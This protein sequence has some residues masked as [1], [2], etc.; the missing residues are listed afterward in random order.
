MDFK[1][2]HDLPGR[3]RLRIPKGT[4]TKK[5]SAV[6]ETLLGV[7][8]DVIS[9]KVSF[10][11]DSILLKFH[12]RSRKKILTAVSLLTEDLCSDSELY[13]EDGQYDKTPWAG[14]AFMCAGAA[15]RMALPFPLRHI[16]ALYRSA[17]FVKK[18]IDSVFKAHKLNVSVLDASAI[19][20]AMLRGDFKAAGIVMTLIS[21]GDLLENWTHK[22]SKED[23]IQS[24][25]LN[26]DKV[27]IRTEKGDIE[28]PAAELRPGDIVVVRAGS[29]I[30]ADGT[31]AEG[32]AVVNQSSMTGEPLGVHRKPGLSV[33][34][35]TIVEEGMIAVK[36][37]AIGDS[38]RINRI[39]STVEES[40]TRKASVQGRAERL[41]DAIVPFNFALALLVYIFTRSALRASAALM[42]DYSCAIKLSTPLAILSAM[43]EGIKHGV[44]I[45]GGRYIEALASAET[46]VF[47]KTG[48]LTAAEPKVVKTIAMDGFDEN[49]MLKLAACLEEHF[50]HSLAKAV[51]RRAEEKGLR[52]AEEHAEVEYIV[53]HGIA[54][55]LRGERVI[56]GSSHFVFEDEGIVMTDDDRRIIEDETS[57]YSLL[58]LAVGQ[59]LAGII[60]ISDPPRE[61][62]AGVI[63]QLRGE[64]FRRIVMLTGDS[65]KAAGNTAELLGITDVFSEMLPTDKSEYIGRLAAEGRTVIMVGDGINDSPALSAAAAG[66]S[67]RSGADIAREVADIVLLNNDLASLGEARRICAGTMRKIHNAHAFIIGIN[68]ALLLA[69]LFGMAAPALSALL[70]N[71]MTVGASIYSMTP[72]L[73]GAGGNGGAK[74]V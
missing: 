35:G 30:P 31:V 15:F 45:K 63:S 68:T 13:E 25:A 36:V 27:W 40:E 41:A 67:M 61:E 34:A 11:T 59:R 70:H 32:E 29:V 56:I 20:C 57:H 16:F 4:L 74:A 73:P 47:D 28:V 19:V 17:R 2:V 43:R 12:E 42:V 64:G 60:C 69:G 33:F 62:A 5:N 51:V 14:V 58:F 48:T 9:V 3:V 24:L 65:R 23:L 38:T 72:V 53:A 66:V 44:L 54:S 21:V 8:Q 7:Q 39:I 10:R 71:L 50:P 37:T 52:H 26:I 18:G 49:E 46:I 6:I 1:I 22:K 55:K